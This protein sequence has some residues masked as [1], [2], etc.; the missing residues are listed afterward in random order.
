MRK[1]YKHGGG[2]AGWN[3]HAPIHTEPMCVYV[4]SVWLRLIRRPGEYL[5]PCYS[6]V[7]TNTN[8]NP[9]ERIEPFHLPPFANDIAN[10]AWNRPYRPSSTPFPETCNLFPLERRIEMDRLERLYSVHECTKVNTRWRVRLSSL[11]FDPYD[12]LSFLLSKCWVPVLSSTIFSVEVISRTRDECLANGTQKWFLYIFL[13]KKCRRSPKKSSINHSPT[14]LRYN[15][16]EESVEILKIIFRIVLFKMKKNHGEFENSEEES[17]HKIIHTKM[18][19]QWNGGTWSKWSGNCNALQS[20]STGTLVSHS[21]S[22]SPRTS[23]FSSH[24]ICLNFTLQ[25]CVYVRVCVHK[26]HLCTLL[27]SR[28]YRSGLRGI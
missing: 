12:P 8:I 15:S 20:E 3:L 18:K 26:T 7:Y 28:I 25:P 23:A 17:I 4:C 21:N 16:R 14:R 24:A 9:W 27:Y 5:P 19:T 1:C 2:C 10:G 11:I 13:I 6:P 22:V